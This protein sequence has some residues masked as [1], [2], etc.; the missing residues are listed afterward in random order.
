[1]QA[2]KHVPVSGSLRQEVF[3]AFWSSLRPMDKTVRI[4]RVNSVHSE[5]WTIHD[6]SPSLSHAKLPPL[7]QKRRR[8]RRS[9]QRDRQTAVVVVVLVE[10]VVWQ[11]IRIMAKWQ[12]VRSHSYTGEGINN[13]WIDTFAF[14]AGLHK[15]AV[16]AS[17]TTVPP[18]LC[19]HVSGLTFHPRITRKKYERSPSL[20]GYWNF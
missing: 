7:R 17:Q 15:W 20:F 1:M 9:R 6:W 12:R 19:S 10:R 3:D 5:V 16:A 8:P 18:A 11:R 2:I 13:M 4:S 14:I